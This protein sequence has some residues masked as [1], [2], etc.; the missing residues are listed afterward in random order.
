MLSHATL[1]QLSGIGTHVESAKTMK[2]CVETGV[3]TDGCTL[4]LQ[5]TGVSD[6]I[7]HRI[8]VSKG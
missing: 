1:Q 6:A 4:T 8:S 2:W 7:V 5:Q 3:D